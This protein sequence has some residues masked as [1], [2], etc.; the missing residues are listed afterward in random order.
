[1][2]PATNIPTVGR[3]ATVRRLLLRPCDDKTLEILAPP[4]PFET[5]VSISP[6]FRPRDYD[7]RTSESR[8]LAAQV[9]FTF[10]GFV[11]SD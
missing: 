8:W 10:D 7:K 11:P 1:V 3:P 6:S 5:T 2:D 9:G 4:A